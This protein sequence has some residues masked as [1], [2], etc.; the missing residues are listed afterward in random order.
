MQCSESYLLDHLVGAGE[1][2][3]RHVE[4]ERLRGD[5]V[6]REI[7]LGRQLDRHF[8]RFLALE[9][10]AGI[11]AGLAKLVRK[12]R[13]VAHQPAGFGKFAPMVHR[14]KHMARRVTSCTRRV[15]NSVLQP[16]FELLRTSTT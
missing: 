6:E 3:R 5:Q 13:S 10:A 1:Q 12:A 4:A 14:G 7:E 2:R 15:T 9:D 16:E 11:D 8:G